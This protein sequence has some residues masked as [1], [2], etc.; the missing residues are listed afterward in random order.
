MTAD[1]KKRTETIEMPF[2]GYIPSGISR[3]SWRQT[4]YA[5]SYQV[6]YMVKARLVP[7]KQL[8]TGS[9][10]SKT[11]WK[12]PNSTWSGDVNKINRCVTMDKEHRYYRYY[13]LGGKSLMTRGSYD[14]LD[15]VVRVRSFN[16][17]KK[18]H[19]AWTTNT[20][21][22]NCVPQIDVHEVIALADGGIR[23]YFATHGWTR[24][25][26]QVILHDVRNPKVARKANK[27]RLDQE[28]GAIGTE[29][30]NG[31]PYAEFDGKYFHYDFEQ[32][33]TIVLKNCFF[34]TCDGVDV[35][36]DGTY[37]ISPIDADI[38]EPNIAVS[39]DE[40]TGRMLFTVTKTAGNANDDWDNVKAWM[41]YED[42]EGEK[43][44]LDSVYSYGSDDSV[45]YFRFM[46]PLDTPLYFRIGISNNLGGSFWKTYS[47]SS[48]AGL[49]PMPSNGK[50]LVNYSDGSETQMK[51][52]TF[53]ASQSASINYDVEK[54]FS[55]K[56][57]HEKE[58][59]F[60]RVKPIAFLGEG[61]ERTINIKGTI[62]ATADGEYQTVKNSNL[63]N[64]LD[65]QTQL[66]IVLVRFPNIE[67]Y[68]ALCTGLSLEQDDE[69]EEFYKVNLTLEEVDI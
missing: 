25:D 24:G 50:V 49:K 19:G 16:K 47:V 43:V 39:R 13:G 62:D 48:I 26:S 6:Q 69:Y 36:I 18:Q 51:N 35:S 17:S 57:Q 23:I 37:H 58:I 55:A 46:P 10:Y 53:N 31:H 15:V 28:V 11:G 14:Q 38:S 56:R 64:W 8:S 2:K 66:G 68:H 45:R 40:I 22:I 7:S 42:A 59:P 27:Y 34:R 32:N 9:K 65:F 67:H 4:S 52:G 29:E 21:R 44:R 3:I 54:S 63:K 1:R 61:I 33:Q 20:L 5:Y 41:Y 12:Y 30:A 60:G